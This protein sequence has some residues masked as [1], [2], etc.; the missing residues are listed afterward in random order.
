MRNMSRTAAS[1]KFH[2]SVSG[3]SR[4]RVPRTDL[5]ILAP[6]LPRGLPFSACDGAVPFSVIYF[7]EQGWKAVR[8]HQVFHKCG[9]YLECAAISNHASQ[10]LCRILCLRRISYCNFENLIF[11]RFLC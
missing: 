3:G 8:L 5:I 11:I 2:V 6:V 7:H 1:T 9:D 10:A 4:S